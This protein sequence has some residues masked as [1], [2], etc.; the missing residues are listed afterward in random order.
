[1]KNIYCGT[2]LLH[3]KSNE[4]GN[5][6]ITLETAKEKVHTYFLNSRLNQ[7]CIS[8]QE[9]KDSAIDDLRQTF[10]RLLKHWCPTHLSGM[11]KIS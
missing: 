3:C 5:K 11:K 1:V 9:N 6:N 4:G 2:A 10:Y 8:Q 7:T